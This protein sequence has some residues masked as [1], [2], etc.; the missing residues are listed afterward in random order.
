MITRVSAI[1]TDFFIRSQQKEEDERHFS[2]LQEW[3]AERS[4]QRKT[5]EDRVEELETKVARKGIQKEVLERSKKRSRIHRSRKVK[6]EFIVHVNFL[7][8]NI[9][10]RRFGGGQIGW[11]E[12][13]LPF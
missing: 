13:I 12:V 7:I 10:E 8:K 9:A 3:I 4:S 6:P 1:S 5:H 2:T 11:L